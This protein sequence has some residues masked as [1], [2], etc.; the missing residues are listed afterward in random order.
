MGEEIFVKLRDCFTAGYT[1]PQYCVDNNIKR[2]LFVSE[3]KFELFLWEINSQFKCHKGLLPQF[4]FTDSN[5]PSVNI[6]CSKVNGVSWINGELT[7]K[8]IS[9]VKLE[10]FDKIILLTKENFEINV[11]KVIR[12]IDLERFFVQQTVIDIPLLSFLQRNP[13]VKLILTNFPYFTRYKGGSEFNEQLLEYWEMIKI[14]NN[15]EGKHI[16]TPFDKLGYTNTQ[17]VELLK[18]ATA[19]INSDGSTVML[20]DNS[21]LIRIQNGK[22]LTAYQPE[23]FQN[24]IYF[25]GTCFQYG[26]QAPFDKTIESYL[27]K[28]LNDNNLPYCVENEGQFYWNRFQDMFYNLN[29]LSPKPGDIIFIHTEGMRSNNSS[30]SFCDVSNAFDSPIDYKEIFCTKRHVNEL[31][32][33]LVAEKYFKFLTENNFFRDKNFNYPLPPPRIIVTAFR[34]NSSSVA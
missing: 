9:A 23:Y 16:T 18:R 29:K 7:I 6:H 15:S 28:M 27:Q 2:P 30:I 31:G 14:I 4:C 32:Y 26:F 5:E 11:E 12:F 19:K 17:V 1:F 8:N 34:L 21:P 33:K 20:D 13:R 10:D 3:K 24:R 22:R 25:F